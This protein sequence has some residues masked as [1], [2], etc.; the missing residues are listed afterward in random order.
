MQNILIN[1]NIISKIKPNDKIYINTDNYMSIEHDS[2]L[3]GLFRFIYNNSRTK[4]LNCLN[5]FYL[6][7]YNYIEDTINSKYLLLSDKNGQLFTD[8][9]LDTN[10]Y[11]LDYKCHL[12][13]DNFITIYNNLV[14]LSHYLKLS[15]T[16]LDNLKKTYISDVVTVS[17]LDII[18]NDIEA[19]IKKINKKLDYINDIKKKITTLPPT[20]K[21]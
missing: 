7:V 6:S 17:K 14:E 8:N 4:N 19:H 16:G 2:A 21:I 10:V 3:Q 20:T 13:N 12:E 1:L 15:I 5:S 9:T 18:I 11:L